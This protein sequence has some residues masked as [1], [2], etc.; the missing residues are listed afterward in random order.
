[1]MWS[2]W[3]TNRASLI[4]FGGGPPGQMVGTAE[5]VIAMGNI[6]QGTSPPE[7]YDIFQWASLKVIEELTGDKA[8]KVLKD[9]GKKHWKLIPDAEVRGTWWSALSDLSD[10]LHLDP[11]RVDRR[12]GRDTPTIP[13]T[14][15]QPFAKLF[16]YG[17]AKA[18]DE[19][20]LS[21]EDRVVEMIDESTRTILAMF[22]DLADVIDAPPRLEAVEQDE[23]SP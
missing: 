8:E 5:I 14:L 15:L 17:N 9:P 11:A 4:A 13:R 20:E 18:R 22:P 16:L 12:H 21:G 1:M 6:V 23:A 7:Y 19:A 3:P 10:H 2:D